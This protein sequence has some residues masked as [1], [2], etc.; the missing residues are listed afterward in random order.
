MPKY[1]APRHTRK[2]L[3][4]AQTAQSHTNTQQAATTHDNKPLHPFPPPNTV[5]PMSAAP[6]TSRQIPQKLPLPFLLPLLL[7]LL[8][9]LLP[10][11]PFLQRQQ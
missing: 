9:P 3:T 11:T 8:P 6:S 1:L 2:P 5:N 7:P 4:C 10:L